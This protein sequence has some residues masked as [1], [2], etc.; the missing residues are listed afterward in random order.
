MA[1]R[2]LFALSAALLASL[3]LTGSAVI[4]AGPP[5]AQDVWA[6][7]LEAAKKEG[8]V[9]CGCAIHPG[10]RAFLMSRWQQDY[11]DIKLDYT[12]A[13]LPDWPARVEAE[14]AAGQYRWDVFF[15]GPGPEVYRLAHE[16]IF[17]PL[18]PA[19]IQPDI[20]NP[21]TWGGWD[22]AFYDDEK[23]YMMSFWTS[24][25]SPYYNAKFVSPDRVKKLG[26]R[27]LL[28]PEFKGKIV[29]WDP[30]VGGSGSNMAQFLYMKL[31]ADGLKKI[32]VDQEAVFLNDS[33]AMADRMVRGAAYFALGPRLDENLVQYKKAGLQIDIRAMGNTP[34]F[35][36]LSTEYGILS[37]F[38]R[39]AHPNAA[40]VFVNWLLSK[41]VQEGLDAAVNIKSRRT[42][43]APP[44]SDTDWAVSGA[45]YTALQ[46]EK[47]LAP[48]QKIMQYARDLRPQ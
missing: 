39:P 33:N 35:A 24:L 2:T 30:R 7:T 20:K 18:L 10:S 37:I 9:V 11:P 14:R 3:T 38:N 32:L 27:I 12:P 47:F 40:K 46:Q 21:K 17:D 1:L 4:A 26:L 29:F 43:V 8:T 6:T 15:T 22:N 28:E 13:T 42:D 23:K 36:G 19:L 44:S 5:S 16:G 34:A 45:N 48:R 25:L 31:G 41:P